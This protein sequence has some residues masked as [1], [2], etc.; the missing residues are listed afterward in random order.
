MTHGPR[1]TRAAAPN[2]QPIV[3]HHGWALSSDDWDA[4]LLY[5]MLTTHADVINPDILAFIQS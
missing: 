4:Q 5:F 2:A 3:F 1:L